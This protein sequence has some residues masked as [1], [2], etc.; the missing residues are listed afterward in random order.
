MKIYKYKGYSI[1]PLGFT[2]EPLYLIYNSSGFYKGQATSVQEA[3]QCIN[4]YLL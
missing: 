4:D 3:K 2:I 1:E